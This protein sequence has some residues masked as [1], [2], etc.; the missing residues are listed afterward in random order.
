MISGLLQACSVSRQELEA[1]KKHLV[2]QAKAA[3]SRAAQR[4]DE[5]FGVME[6]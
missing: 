4:R 6:K 3:E 5:F 1:E 2:D